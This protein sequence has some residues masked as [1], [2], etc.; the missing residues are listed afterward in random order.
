MYTNIVKLKKKCSEK[1]VRAEEQYHGSKTQERGTVP[2]QRRFSAN[3][4]EHAT[5]IAPIGL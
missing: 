1:E 5:T 2:A 4:V 3:K